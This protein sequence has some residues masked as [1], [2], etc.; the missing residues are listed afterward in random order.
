ML[1][2]W[3]ELRAIDHCPA[4]GTLQVLMDSNYMIVA[5]NVETAAICAH[6]YAERCHAPSGA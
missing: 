2:H 6:S 1:N 4:C 5:K 3:S